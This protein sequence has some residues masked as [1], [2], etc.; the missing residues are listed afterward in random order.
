M[1]YHIGTFN[2]KINIQKSSM[3]VDDMGG[4]RLTWSDYADAW[5]SIEYKDGGTDVS[6]M[7]I[8][9]PQ[10]AE[11]TVRNIGS[12]LQKVTGKQLFRIIIPNETG[13]AVNTRR[14]WNI[15]S[16]KIHGEQYNRYKTFYCASESVD[17]VVN[18]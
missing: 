15:N 14:Y 4:Q 18:L 2:E 12:D 8:H 5:A 16:F 7:R 11:I 1:S 10:Y 3:V 13:S 6:E 17:D 9:S